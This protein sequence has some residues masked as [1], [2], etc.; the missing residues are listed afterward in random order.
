MREQ[1]RALLSQGISP[2]QI[3]REVFGPDLLEHLR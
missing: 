1:W 2:Q 3:D